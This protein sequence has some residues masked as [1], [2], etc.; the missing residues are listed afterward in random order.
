MHRWNEIMRLL[1]TTQ[2]DSIYAVLSQGL[3]IEKLHYQATKDP[4]SQQRIVDGQLF[5][6]VLNLRR[7][8]EVKRVA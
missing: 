7:F 1:D 8:A 5:L 4:A 6:T 3:E 2:I